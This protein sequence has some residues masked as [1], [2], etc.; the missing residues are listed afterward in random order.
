MPVEEFV[1]GWISGETF[2]FLLSH[3]TQWRSG[4]GPGTPV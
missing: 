2:F 4:L 3:H 1:A